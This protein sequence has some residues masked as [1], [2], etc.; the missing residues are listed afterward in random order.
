MILFHLS[1][2]LSTHTM[3]PILNENIETKTTFY[4]YFFIIMISLISTFLSFL[5][6]LF[7]CVVCV[8]FTFCCFFF[9]ISC[10]FRLA[11]QK[12]TVSLRAIS[13]K[14]LLTKMYA[15]FTLK[16]NKLFWIV[17]VVLNV[18]KARFCHLSL[19]NFISLPTEIKSKTTQKKIYEQETNLCTWT[20]E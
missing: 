14:S 17:F 9:R 2:R 18:Q 1:L 11:Q 4:V 15:N 16:F 20:C 5:R 12:Q 3:S 7:V 13:K 6:L 8:C 10:N 19:R